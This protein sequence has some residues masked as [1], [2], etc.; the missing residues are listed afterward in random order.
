MS[1]EPVGSSAATATILCTDLVGSTA[2]RA[3]LGEEAA[4]DFWRTHDRL[5]ANAV[6]AHR[7]T[8]AKHVGDGIMATFAGFAEAEQLGMTRELVRFARLSA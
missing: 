2:L 8:V 5:L 1:A 6:T 7:R 3:A 4:E